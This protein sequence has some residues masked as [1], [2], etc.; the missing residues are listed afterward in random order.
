MTTAVKFFK[1]GPDPTNRPTPRDQ[2]VGINLC[3]NCHGKL[4]FHGNN[5]T[6]N[7]DGCVTCHNGNATDIGARNQAQNG[8]C[9]GGT[10]D[11]EQ[12]TDDADCGQAGECDTP[13]GRSFCI[14]DTSGAQGKAC[15]S[16][17]DCDAGETCEI[18]EASIDFKR[19]VHQIHAGN[20]PNIF[21]FGGSLHVYSD[22][23][24]PGRL[25]NC[26]GCHLEDTFYPTRDDR[27]FR[28]A[29]T[30]DTG[31]DRAD[32]EV[33]TNITTNTS[34]CG[35]CHTSAFAESHMVN[36]GGGDF[37]AQQDNDGTLDS[38]AVETCTTCHAPGQD[39]DVARAH[40]LD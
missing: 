10:L 18:V 33:D 34:A 32:P 3:N 27:D 31:G 36:V 7:I 14:D 4:A 24:F 17:A 28:W 30:T 29:T 11:G 12:C 35:S 9:T 19:M 1:I 15:I 2:V 8:L 26:T 13:S 5:R 22:V 39:G 20:S 38:V 21:G 23:V 40:G 25:G 16:T 37:S 6:D